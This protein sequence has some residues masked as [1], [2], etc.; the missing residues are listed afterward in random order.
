MLDKNEDIKIEDKALGES[1]GLDV[2]FEIGSY[3]YMLDKN[4]YD[5]LMCLALV[6]SLGS[7]IGT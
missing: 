7:E 3:N 1:L 2:V 4:E 5:K 6:G